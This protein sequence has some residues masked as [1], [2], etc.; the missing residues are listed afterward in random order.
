LL[1][2]PE[3]VSKVIERTRQSQSQPVNNGSRPANV[4]R[5]P[6]SLN[7]QTSA[8]SA[9]ADDGDG[10]DDAVWDAA[11]DSKGRFARS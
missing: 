8:A 3:F 10:S 1:A 2:D 11:R 4:T 5:L 7:R 9:Q 6:P